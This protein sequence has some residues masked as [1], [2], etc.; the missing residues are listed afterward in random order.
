MFNPKFVLPFSIFAPPPSPPPQSAGP[1]AAQGPKDKGPC[2][3]A[4]PQGPAQDP[5]E[6]PRLQQGCMSNR[7]LYMN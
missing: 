3:G 4:G 2:A 5:A 6:H 1:C 7:R